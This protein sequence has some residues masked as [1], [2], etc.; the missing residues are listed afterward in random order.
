VNKLRDKAGR[1]NEM[2]DQA[3]RVNEMRDHVEREKEN[4]SHARKRVKEN[5]SH[6][7]RVKEMRDHAG[8]VKEMRDHAG[9]VKEIRDHAG[10]VKEMRDHAG[11]IKEIRDHAGRVKETFKRRVNIDLLDLISALCTISDKRS[12]TILFASLLELLL[13][14]DFAM[15]STFLAGT[16]L[17]GTFLADIMITHYSQW[18]ILRLEA[19]SNPQMLGLPKL[20]LCSCQLS[21]EPRGLKLDSY[22]YRH[23]Y[24]HMW[25]QF[26]LSRP[27]LE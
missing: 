23:I 27:Y 4:L 11:R 1:V 7:G 12:A 10:R 14:F 15:G 22:P 16:F 13:I 3:G 20:D 25:Y 19:Q 17:A 5:L 6:A 26:L 2:R 21:Q 18:L 8:R 9:R 24:E